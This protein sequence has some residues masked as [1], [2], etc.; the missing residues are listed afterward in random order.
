[1]DPP[2]SH[3]DQR[4]QKILDDKRR[5]L[6]ERKLKN[7]KQNANKHAFAKLASSVAKTDLYNAITGEH[8]TWLGDESSRKEFGDFMAEHVHLLVLADLLF[9]VVPETEMVVL[10]WSLNK[11]DVVF[12]LAT[13]ELLG[14]KAKVH[15]VGSRR[16]P[17]CP[18]W[19][20]VVERTPYSLPS[21]FRVVDIP[22]MNLDRKFEDDD[23]EGLVFSAGVKKI[24]EDIMPQVDRLVLAPTE[25][26]LAMRMDEE[27]KCLGAP[28]IL[29][30]REQFYN[31]YDRE[32]E[33]KL[34][35]FKLSTLEAQLRDT[36]PGLS[37]AA[38]AAAAASS[39]KGSTN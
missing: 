21:G 13:T 11:K 1:M 3:K 2:K 17:D 14:E 31:I 16:N 4:K 30:A 38:A 24:Q 27:N 25:R 26:S 5:A 39:T 12:R 18:N 10:C 20:L 9:K 19:P 37:G 8:Q 29:D 36:L 35:A 32:Y 33:K 6:E 28:I 23:C 34:A 15:I 22:R 7:A